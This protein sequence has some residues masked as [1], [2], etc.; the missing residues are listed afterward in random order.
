[1]TWPIIAFLVA[2]ILGSLILCLPVCRQPNATLAPLDACFLATSAVCVTGLTPVA[3]GTVL[4]PFGQAVL[5]LLI[6][7]GGLGVITFTSLIFL[8][9]RNHVPF[10][11]REAVSDALLGGS[12][13]LRNFL[14]Q[15]IGLVFGIE[16]CAALLLFLY[17]SAT[18]T[19]FNAVFHAVSAFCN[20]GFSLNTDNMMGFRDDVPVNLIIAGAVFLG[21]IGFGT[22]R[23]LLGLATG[24]RLG[25]DVRRLSRFSRLVLKTSLFLILMGTLLVLCIEFFRPGNEMD[26]GEGRDLAVTAFF[27][28]VIARTAGFNSVD[29][30]TLSDASLIVFMALMFIGGAPGSCAGGIKVVT[31]RVLTGYVMAQFRGDRQ[32]V[33]EGRGVPESNVSRALTLFFLF[34]SIVMCSTFLLC[35]TENNIF[36]DAGKRGEHLLTILFEE[37]SALGTV[38]LSANLTPRLTSPGKV[39][40]MLNMFAGRIGLLSLLMAIQSLQDQKGYLVAETQLPIG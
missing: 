39:I 20:A 19:P 31:F 34:T 35:L 27:Q 1:M 38:G 4:S 10:H 24:R 17:N 26:L 12:F 23:E 16:I 40:I 5:L 11:N 30:T 9:W 2:I 8:L 28:T 14:C 6:Q 21:G 18:F 22:M 32:I 36:A 7:L 15:V 25:A 29:I 33:L 3:V 37:I 13:N